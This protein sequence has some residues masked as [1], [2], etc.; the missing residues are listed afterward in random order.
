MK[1]KALARRAR[2]HHDVALLGRPIV[3]LFREPDAQRPGFLSQRKFRASGL[4]RDCFEP[5]VRVEFAA[6]QCP[7]VSGN[8]AS[9]QHPPTGPGWP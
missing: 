1:Q 3:K 6:C 5:I 2:R 9:L 8:S 7:G 4:K